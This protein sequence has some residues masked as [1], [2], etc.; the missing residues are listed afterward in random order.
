MATKKTKMMKVTTK[1]PLGESYY[2]KIV[3]RENSS[4]W[5]FGKD[6]RG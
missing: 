4:E 5:V 1:R 6:Q 3:E 2:D